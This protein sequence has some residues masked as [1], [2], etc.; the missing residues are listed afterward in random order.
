MEKNG[1]GKSTLLDC[2]L[3]VNDFNGEVLINNQNIKALSDKEYARLVSFIPQSVQINIDYSI[4]DF[5]S[6]GRNPHVKLG[7]SLNDDDYP[8]F[9]VDTFEHKE[10]YDGKI[11]DFDCVAVK[12]KILAK[13]QFIAGRFIMNCCANDIQLYGFLVDGDLGKSFKDRT[14]IHVK[15]KIKYVWSQEYEEEELVLE[16]I[17]LIEVR[18]KDLSKVLDLT[19]N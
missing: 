3:G 12:S 13:H 8:A 10:R 18:G 9:Y 14:T 7:L 6:F 17:E 1:S 16:P 4:R 19:G 11:I 2:L 5:I 15:A